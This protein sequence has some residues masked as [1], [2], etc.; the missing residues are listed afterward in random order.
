LRK[1]SLASLLKAAI[2]VRLLATVVTV[3]RAG[4]GLATTPRR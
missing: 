3:A 1:P 4:A 2:L